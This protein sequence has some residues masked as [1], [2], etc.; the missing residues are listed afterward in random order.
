VYNG[1]ETPCDERSFYVINSTM[2]ELAKNLDGIVIV[3]E[4]RFYGKSMPAPVKKKKC[5][6]IH[7]SHAKIIRIS[8][9][10]H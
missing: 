7:L 4:H 6:D 3:M 1:G 8:L 10:N 9:L 2:A 5:L